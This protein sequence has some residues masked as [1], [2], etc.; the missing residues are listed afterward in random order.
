MCQ[1]RA[2]I[3]PVAQAWGRFRPGPGIVGPGPHLYMKTVFLGMGILMWKIRR[4]RHRLIFNMGMPILVRH[5]YID[6]WD[7]NINFIFCSSGTIRAK[8]IILLTR[9]VLNHRFNIPGW[10]GQSYDRWYP[11]SLGRQVINDTAI[12]LYSV[13]E[14]LSSI[15]NNFSYRWHLNNEKW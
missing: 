7:E 10:L 1:N 8:L 14:S 6:Y 9:V 4:S 2:G 13:I 3:I 12:D 15:M 11:G 5:L